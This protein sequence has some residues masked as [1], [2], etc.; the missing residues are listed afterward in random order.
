[1]AAGFAPL[2][3]NGV[4]PGALRLSCFSESRCACKPGDSLILNFATNGDEYRPMID[5]APIPPASATAIAKLTGQE[6]AIGA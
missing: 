5:G 4:G 6:P 2:R 1:M 3:Y